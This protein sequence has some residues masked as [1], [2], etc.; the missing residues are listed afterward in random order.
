M[1]PYHL[2]PGRAP[3]ISASDAALPEECRIAGLPDPAATRPGPAPSP[4][5][6]GDLQADPSLNGNIPRPPPAC[7]SAGLTVR[8]AVCG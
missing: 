2:G 5:S 8:D 4:G 3:P 7:K 6:S 1:L